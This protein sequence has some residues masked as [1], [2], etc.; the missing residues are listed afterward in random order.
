MTNIPL[1]RTPRQ[2]SAEELLG[3]HLRYEINQMV[4]ALTMLGR[5]KAPADLG[6]EAQK[7]LDN[8]LMECFYLH[9]RALFEFFKDTRGAK[10]Y[11]KKGYK[12]FDGK[13]WLQKLNNQVSHLLL[14]RTAD[15]RLK[16]SDADRIDMINALSTEMEIFKKARKEEFASIGIPVIQNFIL[17]LVPA[18]ATSAIGNT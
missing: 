10:K 8:A 17:P 7:A 4:A 16:I 2:P 6:S 12:G 3:H 11:A 15:E 13:G 14:G 5:V 9:A 1:Q 18:G